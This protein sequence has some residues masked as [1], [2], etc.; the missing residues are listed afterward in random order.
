MN[1]PGYAKAVWEI[2][3]ALP[4]DELSPVKRIADRLGL[5]TSQVAAVVYPEG[6]NFGAWDDSQEP[7]L[8]YKG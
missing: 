7:P 5:Q 8:D 3:N 2:W 4:V 1:Q 6:H